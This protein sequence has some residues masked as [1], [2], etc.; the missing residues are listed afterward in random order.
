VQAETTDLDK[1]KGETTEVVTT[2]KMLYFKGEGK[3]SHHDPCRRTTAGERGAGAGQA[4][5]GMRSRR[6]TKEKKE[7]IFLD[8]RK[9]ETTKV[10]TTQ[11]KYYISKGRERTLTMTPAEEPP[12]RNHHWR[13]IAEELGAGA[14]QALRGIRP[15][16]FTKEKKEEIFLDKRKGETTEVVTT[17]KTPEGLELRRWLFSYTGLNK[18]L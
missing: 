4:L 11:K 16:R 17:Q 5:R 12:L 2:Q 8:K 18:N 10:V 15:R 6:F 9:G 1:C 7:E 14:G 13:T 3:N